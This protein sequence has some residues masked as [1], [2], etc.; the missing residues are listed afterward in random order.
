[1][2][3]AMLSCQHKNL[4][5]DYLV[6]FGCATPYC[7]GSEVHCRD[8]G[9]YISSCGCGSQNGIDGWSWKRR[10]RFQEKGK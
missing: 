5:P 8:C 9:A 7:N 1:M 3:A 10:R 6:S 4:Y 2:K